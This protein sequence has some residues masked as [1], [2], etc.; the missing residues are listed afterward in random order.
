MH[1]TFAETSRSGHY[2][3]MWKPLLPRWMWVCTYRRL[4]PFLEQGFSSQRP[5]H[6]GHSCG[7]PQRTDARAGGAE[8]RLPVRHRP[9]GAEVKHPLTHWGPQ[10]PHYQVHDVPAVQT[11]RRRARP[12]GEGQAITHMKGPPP[13][14]PTP[15]SLG[16]QSSRL[17]D[18]APHN[19]GPDQHPHPI[20]RDAFVVATAWPLPGAGVGSST[21]EELVPVKPQLQQPLLLVLAGA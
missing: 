1:V 11:Q 7:V 16:L 6:G 12:G 17:G 9:G 5:L 14:T 21:P 18:Q 19:P 20:L 8:E 2:L 3:Q 4:P 15:V 10:V 13:R